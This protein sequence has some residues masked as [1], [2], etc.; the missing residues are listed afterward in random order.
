MAVSEMKYLKANYIVL[1]AIDN[2]WR[3][4]P[5]NASGSNSATGAD[6]HYGIFREVI[7]NIYAQNYVVP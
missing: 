3:C 7:K 2:P 1:K 5:A 4:D 6:C